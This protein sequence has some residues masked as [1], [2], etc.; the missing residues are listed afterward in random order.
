MEPRWAASFSHSGALK[1]PRSVPARSNRALLLNTVTQD[2]TLAASCSRPSLAYS[3]A[4]AIRGFQP[5][6]RTNRQARRRCRSSPRGAQISS[7]GT[8]VSGNRQVKI[9]GVN[10]RASRSM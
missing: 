1:K 3:A 7:D 9:I 10:C 4:H 6:L 8:Y 2:F 5:I